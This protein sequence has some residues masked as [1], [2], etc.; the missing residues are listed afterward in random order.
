M[1]NR[2]ALDERLDVEYYQPKHF[3]LLAKLLACSYPLKLLKDVSKK[4]VDGPFGSS[5]KSEDYVEQGI[6]FLRVADITHGDGTIKLDG[7]IYISSEKHQEISRSTVFPNDVVIAKT[8]ATMGAASVV[9]ETIPEANIRGDLAAVI[10]NDAVFANYIVNYI[11]TK[12]GQDLFW[13][14]NSGATR[15]RVVISNLRKYP[16]IVPDTEKIVEINQV[17]KAGKIRKNQKEAEAAA[18]LASI[19]GYL[20]Q[21]LGI[22]LPPPSEKKVFFYSR[23]SKVSGGRSDPFYHQIVFEENTGVVKTGQYQ[24]V[25]LKLLAEKLIKGR[26][27]KDTEKNGDLKVVQIN[28]INPD[29]H[30][31]LS[32]L[33]TAKAIFTPEQQ[34]QTNDVL[35]V[36]TGAT[37]GKIAIWEQ[38]TDNYFLGG[39]IVKFQC[40]K[41]INPHFIFAWLRCQNAQ[42]EIKRNVTGATNGH[43]SPSDIG[44]ILIPCPPLEKQIEIANHINKIRTQAKQLQ[45]QA[46]AELETAKQQV[47][48]MILGEH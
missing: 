16:V 11:N 33:L 47:E 17:V 25:P 31:D 3:E 42:I 29:G 28:S 19:D 4:I 43:L 26:L 15:G 48:R 36:I 12:I 18:L 44:N 35:V 27:P 13:R 24:A 7:L 38:E 32:D 9:P 6:P 34:M 46:E 22:S 10:V 14:L 40:V 23:Y 1:I 5:V 39:D 8:G 2:G 41:N 20:L 21:A 30:I 37:I 45:Q